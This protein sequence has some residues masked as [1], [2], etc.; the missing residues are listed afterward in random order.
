MH[1]RRALLASMAAAAA[2]GLGARPASAQD[3]PGPSGLP[4]P[5][6]VVLR[7]EE[8]N[9][10]AGPGPR[11]PVEWVYRRR[12]MPVEVTAEFDTWR[13]IRDI[14]GAEGWVHQSLLAGGGR[15]TVVVVGATRTLRA[16][17]QDAAAG[18]A[19]AE[20]G[21]IARLRRCRGAWC[22]VSAD[23]IEGWLRRD[24]VWGVY[25]DETVD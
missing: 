24:E 8:V 2:L 20:P 1:D 13:R 9:A 19:R 21:V 6:F 22:E 15:R 25:P 16:A 17:P 5:R 7:A 3:A 4:V 18:V 23:G 12:D 11:Y 14:E 10:R